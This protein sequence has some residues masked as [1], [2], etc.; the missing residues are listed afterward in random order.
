[1]ITFDEIFSTKK[2]QYRIHF[3]CIN[4]KIKIKSISFRP[5]NMFLNEKIL[6]QAEN[7]FHNIQ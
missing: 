1:M 4:L 5:K 7:I 6:Q 2:K 3:E